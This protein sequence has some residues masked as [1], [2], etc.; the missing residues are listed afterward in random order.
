VGVLIALGIVVLSAAAV[1]AWRS[2]RS[3][4]LAIPL[5]VGGAVVWVVWAH[6][7]Y[8]GLTSCPY[9]QS[10]GH[11]ILIGLAISIACAVMVAAARY[12][13]ESPGW[14]TARA[15][16]AGVLALVM[17]L[18]VAFLFGAGLRCED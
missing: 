4:L 7:E 18:V 11:P 10:R 6:H 15:F 13:Q 5:A 12:R 2:I 1:L 17:I 14:A 3:L 16:S 9:D 8:R